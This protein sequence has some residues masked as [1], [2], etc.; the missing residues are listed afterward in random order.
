MEEETLPA[1]DEARPA[2]GE[3][4]HD[5][6]LSNFFKKNTS[7][8]KSKKDDELIDIHVGN[9]LKRITQLLEDIKNQKAF[10]FTLKGSLGI[11]GVA[12]LIGSFGIF[13]GTKAFCQKG[14]Q[15]KI[16][17]IK[18]LSYQD[19]QQDSWVD[20]I[21]LVNS[22]FTKGLVNRTILV[23][24]SNEVFRIILP[25]NFPISSLPTANSYFVTGSL[26]SCSNTITVEDA[27]GIQN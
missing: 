2:V 24:A 20:F 4:K 26:D 19:R 11:M 8:K 1:E 21:P 6:P 9:P 17:N 5:T 22:F 13:G 7:V 15:T 14:V 12:L 3:T 23:T 16:G 10:T 25:S 18:V 27:N